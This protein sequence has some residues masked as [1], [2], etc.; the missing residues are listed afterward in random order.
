VLDALVS[1][2]NKGLGNNFSEGNTFDFRIQKIEKLA[3]K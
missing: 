1:Y 3:Q 2:F